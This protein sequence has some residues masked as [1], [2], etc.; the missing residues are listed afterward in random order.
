M[1]RSILNINVEDIHSKDGHIGSP[2]VC[3]RRQYI[4]KTDIL[5]VHGCAPGG[6]VTYGIEHRFVLRRDSKEK[7]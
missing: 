4:A 3:T 1:E 6:N 7:T 2:W 5:E